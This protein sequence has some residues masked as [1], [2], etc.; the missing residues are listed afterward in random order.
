[1]NDSLKSIRRIKRALV[2]EQFHQRGRKRPSNEDWN[3]SITHLN[4]SM[5]KS[6]FCLSTVWTNFFNEF[7]SKKWENREQ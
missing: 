7:Y 6:V 3:K 2:V 5:M 1:M 4:E